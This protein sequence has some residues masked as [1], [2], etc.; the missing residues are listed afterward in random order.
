MRAW[1]LID[2]RTADSIVK[3]LIP[4]CPPVY[5]G[6]RPSEIPGLPCRLETGRLG[7]LRALESLFSGLLSPSV[8]DWD[9]GL[10]QCFL[11]EGS[12]DKGAAGSCMEGKWQR[13]F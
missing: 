13:E 1:R 8:T 11:S 4:A 3:L 9:K 10:G 7:R 2:K 5:C 12:I 6:D